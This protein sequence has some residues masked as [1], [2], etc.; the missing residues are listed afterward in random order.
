MSESLLSG[1]SRDVDK[2]VHDNRD[3]E[4][5]FFFND[6]ATTEIYTLALQRRSSDLR[7]YGLVLR[8]VEASN[9]AKIQYM[10]VEV[11]D[12]DPE[13]VVTAEIGRAVWTPVTSAYLVC[14]L[15]LEKKQI[16]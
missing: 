3:Q 13:P 11:Q 10:Y 8:R 15:L 14:R 6:T 2:W 1:M 12:V 5:L 16:Q 7:D 9:P 4:H